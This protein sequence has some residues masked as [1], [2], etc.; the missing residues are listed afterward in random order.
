MRGVETEAWFSGEAVFLAQMAA[1]F[2]AVNPWGVNISTVQHPNLNR[3]A[4]AVALAL[5]NDSPPGL[6]V[7]LPEQLAEWRP[8]LLDLTPYAAHPQ[9]GVLQ[10]DILPAFLAASRLEGAQMGLPLLRSGRYLFYNVTWARE[11]GFEVRAA[12]VGG[13]PRA[14]L[15]RQRSLEARCRPRQRRLRRPGAGDLP[16]LADRPTGGSAPQAVM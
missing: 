11:L 8:A 12:H 14:G 3:L 9:W 7:A 16:E 1:E 10:A 15:R 2:N 13:F 4:Q 5:E 6:V